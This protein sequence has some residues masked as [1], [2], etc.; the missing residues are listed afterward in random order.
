[1]RRERV[2]RDDQKNNAIPR[3][4]WWQRQRLSQHPPW[5]MAVWSPRAGFLPTICARW[6]HEGRKNVPGAAPGA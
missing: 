1:M 2:R 3:R 4:R 5:A 6:N